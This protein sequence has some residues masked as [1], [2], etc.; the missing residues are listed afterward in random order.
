M[1]LIKCHDSFLEQQIFQKIE[2]ESK[3]KKKREDKIKEKDK[4][5]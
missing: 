1:A 3:K 2:K 4:R 5:K